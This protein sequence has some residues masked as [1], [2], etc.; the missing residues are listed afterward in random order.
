MSTIR[1]SPFVMIFALLSFAF[2]MLPSV[3]FAQQGTFVPTGSMTAAR[4]R[5]TA[6][7]LT[8]GRVLITGGLQPS[9]YLA[10]AELY[11]PTTGTFSA[12]GN[13]IAARWGH[14][15]TLLNDGKVLVAGGEF[16]GTVELYDPTTGTFSATGNLITP[17]TFHTATLLN[18]GMVLIAGGQNA[19]NMDLASAELYDPTTG[20][21]SATGN[22][23][24]ARQ[25]ATATLLNDGTVL[26]AGGNNSNGDLA[27]AELYDPTSGTFTST[28]SLDSPERYHAATL[29]SDGTVLVTGGID[30]PTTAQLYNSNSGT[31]AL[32]GNLMARWLHT[33]TLLSDGTVL[34]CGGFNGTDD[35]TSAEL[36]V[37]GSGTFIATG[38]L[39]TARWNHTATL[40]SDGKVL[41][42]GGEQEYGTVSLNSAEL[43]EVVHAPVV[44]LSPTSVVFGNQALGSTSASQTVTLQNTG[45]AT[46]NIQAVALAGADP[47]DFAITNGSTCTNG[48]SLTANSSCIIQ[49][50]FTPTSLGSRSASVSITDNAAD[51]PESVSLSGTTTP[52]PLV[53]VTPSS[54]TFTSQFVGTSGLPQ[55]VTVTNNGD[56][57]LSIASVTASPSDFGTLSACGNSLAGGASCSIGVFFDPTTSGART[58][59]LTI[60]DNGPGSPQTVALSGTGEDFSMAS[61]APTATVTAGQTAT[62]SISVSPG[63]GFSQTVSLSCAGAPSLSTCT[64]SPS[65]VALNGM[66]AASV[67]ITVST[68]AP[69][70]AIREGPRMSPPNRPIFRLVLVFML[71]LILA[72][73]ASLI[74]SRR[75][76]TYSLATVFPLLLLLSLGIMMAACGGGGGGGT[77]NPGT[78]TGAYTLIVSGT[79]NSGSASLAHNTKLGLVVQ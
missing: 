29:L 37:P 61:V 53:S 79:F 48:A 9:G 25:Y 12:T 14:T 71:L 11:D 10:S 41:V 49:L 26:I 52:A 62:Y 76:R 40:L 47:G 4:G 20:T 50:T 18:N 60:N 54:A 19:S 21:F 28:G 78:P 3:T 24:T 39:N 1:R 31:F 57:P 74:G 36:Y 42:A 51:S 66:S 22:L 67:K 55:T 69:S 73:M 17:R 32:T 5:P 59:T 38:S 63:G 46:L 68:T 72:M 34:T 70:F 35:L 45:L 8:D 43:Y 6:T 58:G 65:S 23:I 77:K 64:V 75:E 2:G 30:F 7:L 15:A 44:S 33:A 13:L 56:A 16:S 27:S